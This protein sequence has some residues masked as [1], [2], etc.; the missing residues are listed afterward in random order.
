MP[1]RSLLSFLFAALTFPSIVCG[2]LIVT[3]AKV[4][5]G[6][7]EVKGKGAA[8]FAVITWDDAPAATATKSG[9]FKF[10]TTLFPADCTGTVKDGTGVAEAVV[11]FCGPQ[12]ADGPIGPAGP[13]GPGVV[14]LD[15]NDN[16][17]GPVVDR[18]FVL[19]DSPVGPAMIEVEEGRFAPPSFTYESD[20]CSGTPKVPVDN[21]RFP[22]REGVGVKDGVLFVYPETGAVLSVASRIGFMSAEVCAI[23][24]GTFTPPDRC[25]KAENFGSGTVGDPLTVTLPPFVEP[26]RAAL[27]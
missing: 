25:C 8:P 12:G 14:L 7:V 26:F 18:K 11:K 1:I 24:S 17:I 16:V 10:A 13:S 6:A 22:V 5:K 20:D 2:A 15:A 21:A 19:L 4:N 27:R 9:A 23:I 3:D